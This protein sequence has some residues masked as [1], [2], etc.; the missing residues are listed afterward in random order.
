[1]TL[2]Q[3]REALVDVCESVGLTATG[4]ITDDI[5]TPAAVISRGVVEYDQTMGR[6]SD[7][8]LW[9]I[10][11]VVERTD[12]IGA[13]DDLDDWVDPEGAQMLKTALETTAVFQA[14]DVHY[15]RLRTASEVQ[16]FTMGSLTY[17]SVEFDV[18][19]MV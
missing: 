2:K 4:Y 9:K 5:Q 13:Q 19:T 18:E 12:E 3:Q 6:G 16:V 11:V 7:Q 14:A 17:L 8:V 15:F 1:M 10:I